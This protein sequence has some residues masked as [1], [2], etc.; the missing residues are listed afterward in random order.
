MSEHNPNQSGVTR[1]QVLGWLGAAPTAAMLP[2]DPASAQASAGTL[3]VRIGS[4]VGNL[5]PAKIFAIEN[6]T[7]AG[8]IYNGLVKYD[9]KTNKIVPDL[10]SSWEISPD[11]TVFT[12][13]LRDGVK[14]HKG[15]GPLTSDDVKF[16]LERI[17]D[18][19]AA[20]PYR[21]QLA[22]IKTIETPDPLTVRITTNGPAAGLLHKLC[23]FNQG[24]IVSRK[25]VTEIGD[26]YSMQPIGTGPFVFDKWT[27]G[28]EV[29]VVANKEYFEGAPKVNDVIFRVIKD[30]T[31]AAIAMENRE[32]DIFFAMQQPEIIA[33]LSKAK[34]ITM[35]DRLADNTI[36]LVLN[37][38]IKP[39]DDVRVRRAMAH[40]MNRKALIDGYFKGTKS[41]ASTVLTPAFVEYTDDVM[42]YP[43]DPA[44][45]KAL[46]KEAGLE[47][48]FK[49]TITSVGL[50]PYDKIPVPL[51]EDLKDVGI[52]TTVQV[53]ERAAYGQARAKGDV[54]SCVT[55]LVGP[56]DPDSPL[57]SLFSTKSFPPGLNTSRYDKVDDLLAK[58]SRT[59]DDQA[60][61]AVYHDILRKTAEDQP[62]IPIYQDRLFMA[63][64]DAVTGL[65][66]NSLFTVNTYGVS[67][68]G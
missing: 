63:Y 46:L 23:A 28:T 59:L 60:R 55:G 44:K 15:Y 45:A 56:P 36:N 64:T 50:S 38:T 16:S 30:E 51:A 9:Q 18:P 66:Q 22:A 42:K 3:R 57:V 19:A 37:T 65:V 1:R 53:L 6:Q 17:L 20:S 33:R 11:G 27:P 39:L 10:A 58:A 2:W 13:K 48:G 40:A 24:W 32:I 29:R 31:A 8:H 62:V 54:Q 67:F 61:F 52:E 7:V 4:D 68:K 43:Y 14:F 21:G 5:D 25:A 26:K 41:E 34:G 35:M 12:F 49:F 47:K